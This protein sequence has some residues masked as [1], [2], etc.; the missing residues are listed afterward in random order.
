[1]LGSTSISAS[2][3]YV[4]NARRPQPTSFTA[5]RK[6]VVCCGT[7]STRWA[8]DEAYSVILDSCAS[9][10]LPSLGRQIHADIIKRKDVDGSAFLGT[11]LVFMYGK[12]GCWVEA[13][14]LFDEMPQRSVFTYNAMLGAY[15]SNDEPWEAIGLFD[16][17]LFLDVSIDAHTCSC[18]LRACSDAKDK[19]LGAQIHGISVKYGFVSNNSVLVNSL[20]SFYDKCG[21]L[22]S[23]ELLFERSGRGDIVLWNIMISAYATKGMNSE[24]MAAFEEMHEFSVTP[25][26]YTFVAALKDCEELLFGM[27][28][29]ALVF[30]Y[31][32]NSDRYIGNAL[33]VMYSKCRR[34]NEA[35]RIFDRIPDRDIISWNSMLAAYVQCNL[36]DASFD[37][38]TQMMRDGREPDKV[39]VI[40]ALSASGRSGNLLNGM[41]LHGFALKRGMDDDLQVSNTIV[42]MYAKCSKISYME[43]ALGRIPDK[44]SVSYTTMMAGYVQNF[45]YMKA[46]ESF[47]DVILQKI[48]VDQMMIESL[49]QACRG[50]G[51]ISKV[52][53]IH[54]YVLSRGLS[55]TV[56]QNTLVE[57]YGDCGRVK[58]ARNVFQ[59]IQVKNVISW[60]SMIACYIH[61]GLPNDALQYSSEMI[62]SGV[63]LDSISLVSI[64]SA[65]TTLSALMKCREIHSFLIRRCLHLDASIASSLV[66]AYANCGALHSSC[67]VFNSIVDKDLVL[68]TSMMN[69]YGIHGH[70]M[71]AV[72]LFKTMAGENFVP[73]HVTF[74]ALISACSHSGL[75]DEGLAFYNTM[76]C[77][78]KMEP[79]PQ[80]YAC[81]VDLLGRGNRLREAFEL[82]ES[83][84]MDPPPAAV[85]CALLGAC[86]IHSDMEIGEIAAKKLLE[87]DPH[88]PGHYV[89]VSNLYAAAGRWEDVERVR[90]LMKSKGLR[91]DPGCSW[92]EIG[93]KFH[94]FVVN[95][96]SHPKCDAI[97]GKL[98]EITAEVERAGGY[99]A[100]TRCVLHDLDDDEKV[101]M[102]QSHSERIALAYGFLVTAS[103]NPIRIAK[104]L[105][106][107]GD[108]HRFLKLVSEVYRR[109][110]IVRDINRYHHFRDGFCS[111]GDF[112]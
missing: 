61:N 57:V 65:A 42:D 63:E 21:D 75:V 80:H 51:C 48:D 4:E 15:V 44:D 52:R 28:I 81:V 107:C 9:R 18:L 67:K 34:V 12:C 8:S 99:R 32:L 37:F 100:D 84:H 6:S 10:K 1:M 16:E 102:V 58:T 59:H 31:N 27:Q 87:S 33:V 90:S 106:V 91:K 54:G 23:A 30:K 72:E 108:C 112:W 104:N 70:G 14:E 103:A 82:V 55:D 85:W 66:N 64:L 50:M 22:N 53:E 20:V 79:W 39:S 11:K 25:T 46:L 92:I 74:L 40:S 45:C 98:S 71:A 77:E 73:D 7:D 47:H 76:L 26:A 69:A 83:M 111:C 13:E 35:A 109:E 86:R 24:A 36:F 78:Y 62:Q 89:L 19:F 68:R 41:E 49:L 88:D 2:S 94:S 101:K 29:H 95:D 96:R 93:N 105:R 110:I 5:L 97:Y 38:F 43:S 60:T 17:M 3:C 56:L